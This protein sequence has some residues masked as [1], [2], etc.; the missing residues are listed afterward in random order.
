MRKTEREYNNRVVFNIENMSKHNPKDF[1]KKMKQLGPRNSKVPFKVEQNG[2]LTSDIENVL[3]TWKNEFEKLFN[4]K[5]TGDPIFAS[6]IEEQKSRLENEM[7][8]N[9][10]SQLNQPILLTEVQKAIRSCK[11]NKSPGIDRIPNEVIKHPNVENL[12][13]KIY[14]YCFENGIVPKIWLRSLIKPI[15]KS[16]EKNPYLPLNYRGISLISCIGKVYSSILNSRLTFH[17]E[18]YNVLVDE[19]NGFRKSR[20]CED[21]TFV[22]SSIIDTRKSEGKATFAAFIDLSK[23]FDSINRN[24]L[25]YKLLTNRIHGKFYNAVVALYEETECCVQINNLTTEWFGTLQGVRQGDNLSPTLFNVYIND[26]AKDLKEMGLGVSLDNINICVLLYA[27]DIVLIS[28]NEENLQKMLDYVSD[29]CYKWQ[30]KVNVDKTKIVHFRNKRKPRSKFEYKIN[31]SKIECV[32]SYQY[33]GIVFDE[34]L[35]FEKCAKALT[36]SG[37]RALGSI[38][39]KFKQFKNVGYNTFTK[40]YD[41]GVNSIISYGASVWGHGNDK[42]GQL[43]QNRAMRYFLGVHK[44][45]PIHAIQADMGW[46]SVKYQYYLCVVRFWNRLVKMQNDRLTKRVGEYLLIHLNDSNWISRLYDILEKVKKT[47]YI[48]EG[49]EIDLFEIKYQFSDLMHE[50]WSSS[51]GYKPKLRNYT[52]FKQELYVEDYVKV[53]ICRMQ[54]SLIAQLRMGILPLNIETGRYFRKPLNERLC[55]L[56]DQNQI[57]DEYHFLCVCPVYKVERERFCSSIPGFEHLLPENQLISMM[58]SKITNLVK[59]VG[60]I[61]YKRKMLMNVTNY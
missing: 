5:Q 18:E 13:L 60:T 42:F 61:W 39:S 52:K 26:L 54:R 44:N 36:D 16:A 27:D 8:T 17:L 21:H 55:L 10:E 1:W 47:D 32:D 45:A 20:S 46:T 57:E 22:L 40:L 25:F 4:P 6:N 50:E 29:W 12:L 3:G 51:V 19:Q 33:L 30:M 28:E 53:N 56:C 59:Y 9:S 11:C 37:G 24:M 48:L 41:T 23:A 2:N 7:A 31:E 15:P 49:R 38:I 34:H 43:V 35:T 58:T 14:Q